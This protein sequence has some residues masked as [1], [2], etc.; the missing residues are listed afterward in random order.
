[1]GRSLERIPLLRLAAICAG[2]SI[3]VRLLVWGVTE[4]V[5]PVALWD[6]LA[7]PELLIFLGLLIATPVGLVLL[8]FPDWRRAG[9]QAVIPGLCVLVPWIALSL[10]LPDPI[11][12]HIDRVIHRSRPLIAALERHERTTGRLPAR[13]EELTPSELPALPSI[14]RD[15]AFEFRSLAGSRTVA[16]E[17]FFPLCRQ[18]SMCVELNARDSVVSI[19][20]PYGLKPPR[21]PF[22]P[23]V[24]RARPS[25]RDSMW[26]SASTDTVLARGTLDDLTALLGP[27]DTTVQ[28]GPA[29]WEI[30]YRFTGFFG[31]EVLVYR[32]EHEY[33]DLALGSR[34]RRVGNWLHVMPPD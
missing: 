29:R 23:A 3:G 32:P 34:W 17:V 33:P 24:W 5:N 19:N 7:V 18:G 22:D 13:L 26:W 14:A 16:R 31:D 27:P 2:A 10:L 11:D 30:R 12:S 28:H 20:E 6:L 4:L 8:V 15:P 9:L 21:T 25:A 1:M